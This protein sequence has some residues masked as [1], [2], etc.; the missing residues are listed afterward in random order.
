MIG[1]QNNEKI[2]NRDSHETDICS[3]YLFALNSPITK[4]NTNYG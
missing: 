4:K 2:N 1:E 3:L